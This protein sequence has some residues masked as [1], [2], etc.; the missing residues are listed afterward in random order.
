MHRRA[1]SSFL[2]LFRVR[3]KQFSRVT[4]FN[5]SRLSREGIIVG[6]TRTIYPRAARFTNGIISSK[7]CR[8]SRAEY[9]MKGRWRMQS[10]RL[11]PPTRP[12]LYCP[13]RLTVRRLVSDLVCP[14]LSRSCSNIA[15][16]IVYGSLRGSRRNF[17]CVSIDLEEDKRLT[18]ATVTNRG[19]KV[20]NGASGASVRGEDVPHGFELRIVAIRVKILSIPASIVPLVSLMD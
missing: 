16:G 20:A 2:W 19:V 8:N 12:A 18:T 11:T 13:L 14:K 1:F 5:T 10:R 6:V 3:S 17:R 9:R 4:I 7:L 15:L